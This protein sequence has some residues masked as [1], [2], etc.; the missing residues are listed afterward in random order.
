[1]KRKV[2]A[3]SKI[4][5]YPKLLLIISL[6]V[7]APVLCVIRYRDETQYIWSFIIPAAILFAF[8]VF[9]A[10]L[11]IRRRDEDEIVDWTAPLIRGSLPVMFAWAVAIIAGAV[12][13]I[14]AGQLSVIKALFESVSGW[15]T[16]GLTV[17]DIDNMP[18]IFLFHRAFMQYCGG[19]GFVILIGIII[20]G[21]SVTNMY[22]TEGHP[23]SM[24]PNVR[25][26]SRIIFTLYVGTLIFGV[27]IY[28]LL[29]MS[30]FDAIC[31][32]MSA[33]STAGFAPHSDSIGHFNSLPLE[34]FTVLLMLIGCSNFAVLLLLV[35]GKFKR[36]FKSAEFRVML[37]TC[38]VFMPLIALSIAVQQNRNFFAALRESVFGTV[39]LFSTTGYST[40]DYAL[41]PPLALGLLFL[42]MILGGGT[43]STAGGI[44]FQRVYILYRV[45]KAN[46]KRRLS[47]SHEVTVV[48]YTR[49]QGTVKLDSR[50]I[51]DTIEF[52][53]IYLCIMVAGSLLLT[54]TQGAGL[55][56]AFF[57]FTSALGTVGVTNGLTANA[58][59]ASLIV[60][61]FGM[62]LGR[63]EIFIV[64][65]G[66]Y[67]FAGRI[68]KAFSKRVR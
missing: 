6:L 50:Q 63:L 18:H 55:M 36:I 39:T 34:L 57:E 32:T 67:A 68:R 8:G 1:M 33:I 28:K 45:T 42:L 51:I 19:L 29:G 43:G 7:C 58:N 10:V 41:W 56:D 35:K 22:N 62:I 11:D 61:M 49:P 59:I 27:C 46:I 48:R 20:Q 4:G 60:L 38:A 15:S 40:A 12:P 3:Y 2:S 24:M 25:R 30:F 21:R 54:V 23:D 14:I 47:P 52:V 26:A 17:S 31:Y 53:T 13:F 65:T 64:F 44:K 9:V 66:I 16:T 5:F 37:V